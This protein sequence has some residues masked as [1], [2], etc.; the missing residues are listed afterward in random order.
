M[1]EATTLVRLLAVFGVIALLVTVL[2]EGGLGPGPIT[3]WTNLQT[4]VAAGVTFPTFSDPFLQNTAYTIVPDG[5]QFTSPKEAFGCLDTEYWKCLTSN[6]GDASYVELSKNASSAT[7]I[8]P[9]MQNLTSILDIAFITLD[10]SCKSNGQTPNWLTEIGTTIFNNPYLPNPVHPEFPCP[11]GVYKTTTAISET[12][13][14]CDEA[15][16]YYN[17]NWNS[18]WV[19]RIEPVLSAQSSSVA[20]PVDVSYVAITVYARGPSGCGPFGAWYELGDNL[21]VVACQIGHFIDVVVKTVQWIFNGVV[22]V[23]QSVVA[24]LLFFSSVIIGT[25]L[26][27]VGVVTW[28]VTIPG[29]PESVRLIF[30]IFVASIIGGIVYIAARLLR[31]SGPA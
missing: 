20:S 7:T 30:G 22:F 4:T 6:D 9:T 24:V 14:F 26:G 12:S 15:L 21:Q 2:A 25:I 13:S 23:L 19:A 5:Q 1:S 31:G 10:V 28:M 27:I 8:T 29:A 17:T 3:A 16:C 11:V 18:S